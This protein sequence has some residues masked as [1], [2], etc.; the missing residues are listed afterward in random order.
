MRFWTLARLISFL[1]MLWFLTSATRSSFGWGL[2]RTPK[3][4]AKPWLLPKSTSCQIPQVGSTHFENYFQIEIL[5]LVFRKKSRY[6]NCSNQTGSRAFK[7]HWIFWCLGSR[8][9]KSKDSKFK[10]LINS[11]LKSSF[12]ILANFWSRSCR[13]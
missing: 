9:I 3:N 8:V 2:T 7:F 4:V 13:V 12:F 10:Q 6:S 11:L 5:V 1:K